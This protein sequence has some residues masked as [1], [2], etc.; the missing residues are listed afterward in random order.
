VGVLAGRAGTQHGVLGILLLI[1][2]HVHAGQA[3]VLR[4]GAGHVEGLLLQILREVLRLLLQILR[5]ILRLLLQRLLVKGLAEILREILR[6]LLQRLRQILR[7]ALDVLLQALA[8]LAQILRLIEQLLLLLRRQ[9]RCQALRQIVLKG[10]A[11]ILLH[12]LR[13]GL[14]QCL[15]QVLIERL[16]RLDSLDRQRWTRRLGHG[17]LCLSQTVQALGHAGGDR[18]LMVRLR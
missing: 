1:A 15:A 17:L 10:L 9:A 3:A 7:L 2:R 5:E 12:V 14:G 11:K 4:D 13:E 6:L 8:R 16:C 18:A